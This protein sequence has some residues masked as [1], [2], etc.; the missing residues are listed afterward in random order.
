MDSKAW[1]AVN[2]TR[3]WGHFLKLLE[4]VVENHILSGALGAG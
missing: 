1:R 3:L 2:V 4:T